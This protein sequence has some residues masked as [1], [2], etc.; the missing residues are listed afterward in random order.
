MAER[1]FLQD[2]SA[3]LLLDTMAEGVILVDTDGKIRVW[4]KAMTEI[5]GYQAEEAL[6]RTTE[7]LRSA[8]CM[9]AER[10]F[11]LFKNRNRGETCIN[12]CECRII[13]KSGEKI[14]VMVN[15]RV[16]RNDQ[17]K[18]FGILQTITDFRPVFSLRQEIAE[19]T[20]RLQSEDNFAGI[21]GKSPL[22]QRI[23]RL[24]ALAAESEASVMVLG[25]S[26]TGKELVA[27]AIQQLSNRKDGPFIK[28][29]CGAL[30]ESLLE[31]ELFGH[32]K[33]AFTG[34]I[35]KRIGRFE[36]ADNGTIFLDE[37][38]DISAA[39]QVKLLRVLQNGEMQRVGSDS[40]SKVDVR[41]I[42]ATN[43]DLAKEVREGRFREDLYYRLK[44]FPISLPALRNRPE[45]IPLLAQYFINR[46]SARTGR[47][48]NGIERSALNAMMAYQWPGNVRELENA[49]EYAFVVCQGRIIEQEHLPAELILEAQPALAPL[50]NLAPHIQ[51]RTSIESKRILRDAVRLS[52][53]LE[54]NL[55]NKAE[56]ARILGVSR[57]AVWK[58]MKQHKIPASQ[59]LSQG[60]ID[61]SDKK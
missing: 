50:K 37:I 30:P 56:V 16:M 21:T 24:I 48:I 54:E 57:T 13:A 28:V 55:W 18:T 36:A 17:G 3:T 25:E 45:D 42:A 1:D 58:W 19:M 9:G 14:P 10:I 61:L 46:F 60:N 7:W 29:N 22:M 38:A 47:L 12:G 39:M 40:I 23:F 8:E 59:D 5:T 34:A 31:S 2:I 49:I 20:S 43:K 11:A 44:V 6:N 51:A 27:N 33:G 52:A 53:L 35:K 15:A 4:N 26:G 41:V 32:E